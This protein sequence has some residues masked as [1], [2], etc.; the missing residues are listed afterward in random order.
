MKRHILTGLALLMAF[1]VYVSAQDE[2][3]MEQEDAP[4]KV[5]KAQVKKYE[6]RTIKGTVID[7]ATGNPVSGAIVKASGVEGYS[8]LT[9]DKGGYTLNV[10]VF[11][12]A[13]FV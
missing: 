13:V 1:P 2:L 10:P 8:T 6:T 3:D 7:A 9:D 5:A 11:S 4:R 12:S